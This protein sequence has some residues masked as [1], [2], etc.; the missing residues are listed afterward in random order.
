MKKALRTLVTVSAVVL[1]SGPLFVRTASAEETNG[2]IAADTT[3]QIPTAYQIVITQNPLKTIYS[4]G[5]SLDLTGLQ[6]QSLNM[7]EVAVS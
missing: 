3:V 6:V 1:L 4:C 5:E 7:T 2:S